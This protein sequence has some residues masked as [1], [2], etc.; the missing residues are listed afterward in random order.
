MSKAVLFVW[1]EKGLEASE[2]GLG[3]FDSNNGLKTFV[4]GLVCKSSILRS[5]CT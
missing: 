4:E 2:T 1:P 5:S 3:G